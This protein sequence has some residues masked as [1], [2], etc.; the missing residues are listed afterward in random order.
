MTKP[1]RKAQLIRGFLFW[2]LMHA[3]LWY[4]LTNGDGWEIGI[5]S[6]CLASLLALH[7]ELRPWRLRLLYLPLFLG[8]FM[9]AAFAGAADVARRSLLPTCAIA[10]EWVRYRFIVAD[11]RVRLLVSAVIGLFPGTLASKIDG[12][13]LHLHIL[14]RGGIDWRINVMQL[15][16]QLTRL[17][18]PAPASAGN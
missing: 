9:R 1:V 17:L 14:D 18:L 7:L 4:L 8:F 6:A 3:G 5:P 12:D 13:E 2:L 11:P 16:Q 10:P 15:E